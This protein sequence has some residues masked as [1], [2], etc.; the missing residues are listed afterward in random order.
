MQIQVVY[1]APLTLKLSPLVFDFF[2]PEKKI[3]SVYPIMPLLTS[4]IFCID[5][6]SNETLCKCDS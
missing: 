1:R 6:W 2:Y 5:S 3:L 4:V